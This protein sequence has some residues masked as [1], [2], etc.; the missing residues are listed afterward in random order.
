MGK[1]TLAEGRREGLVNVRHLQSLKSTIPSTTVNKGKGVT[2][3]DQVSP[4]AIKVP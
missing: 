4:L 3:P 2:E 1:R